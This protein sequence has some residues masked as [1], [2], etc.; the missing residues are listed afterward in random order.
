VLD[1]WLLHG[2]CNR[3]ILMD[4]VDPIVLAKDLHAT[5][6]GLIETAR[7]DLDRVFRTTGVATRDF[8]S[9]QGHPRRLA[10]RFY[11]AKYLTK[12]LM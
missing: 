8:A 5:R 11:F 4:R 9:S 10:L 1:L 12:G 7:R 6:Y 2:D 3:Q